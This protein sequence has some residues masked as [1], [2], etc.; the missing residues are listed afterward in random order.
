MKTLSKKTFSLF[1]LLLTLALSSC[2]IN[3]PSF[4]QQSEIL[5]LRLFPE[6]K[7]QYDFVNFNGSGASL[8]RFEKQQ[9]EFSEPYS[10]SCFGFSPCDCSTN[11]DTLYAFE[12]LQLINRFTIGFDFED[13]TS[14]IANFVI[15]DF[16]FTVTNGETFRFSADNGEI[17]EAIS[18]LIQD[19]I[20][21]DGE[22]FNDV[23]RVDTN[24]L[25]ITL[26]IERNR[27]LRGI[28]YQDELYTLID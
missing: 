27:G 13:P 8:L 3:C 22:T 11:H 26:F 19:E 12:N 28:I 14:T 15:V 25:N 23:L 1:L 4:D 20:T 21:I 24:L 18:D 7:Q 5:S 17:Q 2:E 10:D 9:F 6:D 16:N